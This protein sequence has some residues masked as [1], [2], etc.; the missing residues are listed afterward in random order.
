[1][2]VIRT[3]R[4]GEAGSQRFLRKYGENLVAVRYR[5]STQH[6]TLCT[7][8]ELIVNSRDA[9]PRSR[10]NPQRWVAVRVAVDEFDMRNDIK[11]AGGR[12]S[13]KEKVWVLEY[14][15][16]VSLNITSRIIPGLAAKCDDVDFVGAF[17]HR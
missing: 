3:I 17:S 1:M 7:T 16:A 6:H 11:G 14:S 10:N 8:I 5:K 13:I 15:E 4:A 2:K 9:T 12:W